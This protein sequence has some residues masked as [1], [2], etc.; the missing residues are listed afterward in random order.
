MTD[1]GDRGR[2]RALGAILGFI[3]G[4]LI[5]GGAVAPWAQSEGI[6]VGPAAIPGDVRGWEVS[7]GLFAVAAGVS[8]L[9]L[10]LIALLASRR[11]TRLLGSGLIVAALIAG[12]FVVLSFLDLDQTFVDFAIARAIDA[13]VQ[14]DGVEAS[15]R[16]LME[17]GS[18]N[19]EPGLGLWI[20]GG[21]V[22]LALI[23]GS[24][25]LVAGPRPAKATADMGF[26][27]TR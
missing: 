5:V 3:G 17:L 23:G 21:G 1:R 11:K 25:L 13:G 27:S 4:A 24:L 7:F 22:V 15:I 10:A 2:A 16:Q 18:L 8:A 6:S 26:I 14:V 20:S 12:T 9:I 19:I